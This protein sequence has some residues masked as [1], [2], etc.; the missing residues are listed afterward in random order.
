MTPVGPP[1][2]K[3]EGA[4]CQVM[5]PKRPVRTEGLEEA[6]YALAWALQR[7][8]STPKV[9]HLSSVADA[10]EGRLSPNELWL[11]VGE[12]ADP[13]ADDTVD[14]GQILDE[15]TLARL[16]R[17][18]RKQELASVGIAH[19]SARLLLGAMLDL[20]PNAL[21]FGRGPCGKPHLVSPR[22]SPEEILHFNLSHTE[23][24]VSVALALDPVGVDIE[25]QRHQPDFLEIAETVFAP[26]SVAA[27]ANA[28]AGL[29][30]RSLFYRYWTLGEA[31]IK[32]TGGGMSHDLKS[33]AFTSQGEPKLCRAGG[34]FG[35][36]EHWAFG[37]HGVGR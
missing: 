16:A 18:A 25:M 36:E 30:R 8:G 13:F 33:F 26:E 10:R 6:P 14:L 7:S 21:S 22:T 34:E 4:D 17:L 12:V 31:L 11:W 23:G 37:I 19:A 29:Q 32:A 5:I 9:R 28:A 24:A 20:P 3:S 2:D 27:V 15:A 35:L 1:A